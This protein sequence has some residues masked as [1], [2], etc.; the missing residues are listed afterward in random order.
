M[1]DVALANPPGFSRPDMVTVARVELGLA[2]LPLLRHRLEVDHMTLV[3]PDVVLETDAAGHTNWLFTRPVPAAAPIAPPPEAA[4][5]PPAV[6]NPSPPR[7]AQ[8]PQA[9][10]KRR[11][12]VAFNGASVVDGRFGFIDGKVRHGYVA[13]APR[14]NLDTSRDGP[15]DLT[16]TLLFDGQT[17]AVSGHADL[18]ALPETGALPVTLKLAT[19]G[20]TLT[21]AGRIAEPPRSRGYTLALDANVPD[22][23]VLK[24]FFARLPLAA[25]GGVTAHVGISGNG[26]TGPTLS[27]L[28]VKAGSVDLDTPGFVRLGHEA[29]LNDVAVTGAAGG[30]IQVAANLSLAGAVSAISGTIGD[31][32]WLARG[33]SA[34]VAVDLAWRGATARGLVRGT[35]QRPT[36]LAGLA[37]DVA[38]NVPNPTLVMHDAPAALRDVM[39]RARLSDASGP[40]PFQLTS[41]AGDLTGQVTVSRTPRLTL[42]GQIWSRHLDLDLL[43]G[44]PTAVAGGTAPP[45][46]RSPGQQVLG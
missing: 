15:A 43:R 37:L 3:R 21:A 24:P 16:G 31:L 9:V 17:I 6:T 25:F 39:F 2:L 13:E 20:A 46:A 28:Q 7:T 1:E 41:N 12:T 14:L 32:P 5:P 42:D 23:A 27:A 4:P 18:A 38:V 8:A 11:F 34:P 40:T 36:R 45:G 10:A 26:G 29:K 22:P 19:G 35:I 30:P 44:H 33:A